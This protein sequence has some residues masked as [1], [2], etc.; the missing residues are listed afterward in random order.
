MN[1]FT[2]TAAPPEMATDAVVTND[3]F[4]PQ[5]TAQQLRDACRLDGTVSTQRLAHALINALVD[6]N[7]Q[8]EDLQAQ[9]IEDG[10]EKLADLPAKQVAGVSAKVHHYTRAVYATVQAALT[11]T[12]RAVDTVVSTAH[13]GSRMQL[14]A[15]VVAE[16]RRTAHN[17]LN[18]LRGKTRATVDL[19]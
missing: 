7:R 5:I 16:Y 4:W 19:L 8:L 10:F 13:E 9:A 17:A 6:I 12:S 2:A 1:G 3:S 14:M 11:E 15:D 18:D